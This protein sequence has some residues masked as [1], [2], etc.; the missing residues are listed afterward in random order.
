MVI[1]VCCLCSFTAEKRTD[2]GQ[3]AAGDWK[4]PSRLEVLTQS[5][6]KWKRER[7]VLV[8]NTPSQDGCSKQ[9]L[10]YWKKPQSINILSNIMN[11]ITPTAPRWM[12]RG[13]VCN[14]N[15]YEQTESV[16][17]LQFMMMSC[18]RFIHA[19]LPPKWLK[20]VRYLIRVAVKLLLT[21]ETPGGED[22]KEARWNAS[23]WQG[24]RLNHK[25]RSKSTMSQ[26][27]SNIIHLLSQ[28][29]FVCTHRQ[30]G[31]VLFARVHMPRVHIRL[32]L[33]LLS[34]YKTQEL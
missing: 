34:L 7:S 31:H 18:L 4:F 16:W 22:E 26:T 11:I 24:G 33:Y 19:A 9:T 30:H 12:W 8:Q 2:G 27:S 17:H 13:S 3:Q 28:L 32:Y 15:H 23:L 29:L 25:K 6:P 5:R 1:S 10:I 14:L 21:T 20:S